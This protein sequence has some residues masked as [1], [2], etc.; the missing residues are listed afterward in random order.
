MQTGGNKETVVSA[1]NFTSILEIAYDEYKRLTERDPRTHPLPVELNRCNCPDDVL[2][3][4]RGQLQALTRFHKGDEKLLAW[5]NPIIH[6][7]FT[8]SATLGDIGLPFSPAKTIF[9]GVAVLLGV[10]R[11]V[12]ASYD[13]L[14]SLFERIHFFLERM[15]RYRAIPLTT[16]MVELLGKIM[17]QV[18]SI[19]ALSTKAMTEGRMKRFF[20][21]LAGQKD[22]D[23]ALLRL[24]TLTTEETVTTVA[25]NLEVTHHVKEL[26]ND[27][28]DN[29]I[30]TKDAMDQLTRN[31]LREKLR[32]WLSPPD[33]SI[34]HNTA[35]ETQHRVTAN[36]FIQ[37]NTFRDWKKNG[38]LLWIR[39]NRTSARPFFCL[40]D[41]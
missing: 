10:V 27:I 32:T 16:A 15:N 11:A 26:T 33:P 40:H 5:L 20:K 30:I 2:D 31:Q 1:S 8:F 4:F 41:R 13:T 6:I 12:V 17:A 9:T 25:R 23:D 7:L 14:I 39:G 36:W 19:L 24:D 18:L 28:R 29:V 35:R 22:I 38:S 34:N 21:G 37:G 3:V